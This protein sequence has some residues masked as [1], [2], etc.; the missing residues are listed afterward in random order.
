[1]YHSITFGDKNTWDDWHLIPTSR[2]VFSPPPLKS[3]YIDIPG[4]DGEA[5]LTELLTGTPKFG[6]RTGSFEFV[7]ANDYLSWEVAYSIIMNYLHGKRMHAI[8]EDEPGY[9]YDGRF[10]ISEW[11]S[12]KNFATISIDYSV[13]P[14]KQAV[15]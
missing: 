11:R 5:D 12:N 14:H 10:T 6:N 1:M 13:G 9:Y 8:L 7:V 3:K 4:G 2:P 15:V